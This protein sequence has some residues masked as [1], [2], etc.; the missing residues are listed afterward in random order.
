MTELLNRSWSMGRF[1]AEFRQAFITPIV[2]KPELHDATDASSYRPIS[3]LSVSSKLLMRLVARQLMEYVLGAVLD[4]VD[5]DILLQHLRLRRSL[6]VSTTSL[7][8]GFSHT[9][10][11]GHR[12]TVFM[13]IMYTVHCRR[14][15]TGGH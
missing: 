2:M 1:H 4:T 14:S 8:S 5:H 7:S 13:F 9:C 10:W 15:P 12:L 6:L 3:N 11:D